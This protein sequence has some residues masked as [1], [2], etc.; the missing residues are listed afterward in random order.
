MTE[1]DD[2][3]VVENRLHVV[4]LPKKADDGVAYLEELRRKM[5]TVLDGLDLLAKMRR[6]SYEALLREGFTP[7]QALY[8]C[9]RS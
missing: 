3:R 5:P 4:D 2:S 9:W 8:L 1:D 7:E 6:A